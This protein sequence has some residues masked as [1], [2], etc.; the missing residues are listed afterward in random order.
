MQERG[1]IPP[2][3]KERIIKEIDKDL[4]KE[5]KYE[6]IGSMSRSETSMNKGIRGGPHRKGK[7]GERRRNSPRK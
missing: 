6:E 7:G 2:E 4:E 5:G 1:S 3:E